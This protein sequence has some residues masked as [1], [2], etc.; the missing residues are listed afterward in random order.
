MESS[1]GSSFIFTYT[2][3][4]GINANVPLKLPSSKENPHLL[5]TSNFENGKK[6][7]CQ[8]NYIIHV[9]ARHAIKL[10]CIIQDQLGNEGVEWLNKEEVEK[11]IEVI[12]NDKT[13]EIRRIKD[14][15]EYYIES[16]QEPDF[17]EN[18][19]IYDDIIGLDEVELSGRQAKIKEESDTDNVVDSVTYIDSSIE[20]DGIN[21]VIKWRNRNGDT[22]K[23]HEL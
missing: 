13:S 8:N 11:P 14:D 21:K 4:H 3:K 19:Y 12:D 7:D 10:I 23:R 16:A 5:K 2:F 17:E 18:E 15:I 6:R 1:Q 20:E 22:G 9:A